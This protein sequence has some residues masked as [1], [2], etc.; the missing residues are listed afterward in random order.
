MA[1]KEYF[2]E[3]RTTLTEATRSYLASGYST[4]AAAYAAVIADG[5]TPA[6]VGGFDSR[7][8]SSVEEMSTTET[9]GDMSWRVEVRWYDAESGDGGGSPEDGSL[10]LSFEI[11]YVNQLLKMS[12]STQKYEGDFL[13]DG[14]TVPD[15]K[16]LINVD[17]EGNVL[18]AEFPGNIPQQIV[19]RQEWDAANITTS[20]YRT[21]AENIL[22]T[23]SGSWQ[24]FAAGEALFL[25]ASGQKVNSDFWE[26]T[27]KFGIDPVQTITSTAGNGFGE[28][29]EIGKW[30]P[31]WVYYARMIE[32]TGDRRFDVARPV[33]I[34]VETVAESF[35]FADLDPTP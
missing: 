5:G 20:Y 3:R 33:G 32:D 28:D 35:N 18:G 2:R 1:I 23:N 11:G 17:T 29:V 21:L 25:G 27:Y 4:E 13:P 26:I 24:G 10:Y 30:R 19:I 12:R 34:Y 6:S 8:M 31:W 7:E 16:G 14:D 22:K 15:F 9:S